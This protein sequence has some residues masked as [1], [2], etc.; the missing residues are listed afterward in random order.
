MDCTRYTRAFNGEQV[1]LTFLTEILAKEKGCYTEKSDI[2]R[3]ASCIRIAVFELMC[4]YS[5]GIMVWEILARKTPFEGKA[6]A[7]ITPAVV[8]GQRPPINAE[9]N[10]ALIDFMK[11][12]WAPLHKD[13]HTV[14]ESRY[15][16]WKGY[17]DTI[18]IIY[19]NAIESIYVDP[20][21]EIGS[22]S[23]TLDKYVEKAAPP[24][25]GNVTFVF[26]TVAHTAEVN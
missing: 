8:A 5:I 18:T 24:P 17:K 13:R 20:D 22:S 11:R 3:C 6:A 4:V 12:C 15:H 7:A 14:I 19:R 9:W 1:V 2:Y 26:S 16:H 21:F 25:T 23:T 10:S